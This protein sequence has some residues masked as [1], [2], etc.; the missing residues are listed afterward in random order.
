[1]NNKPMLSTF[2]SVLCCAEGGGEYWCL[3][4]CCC[5]QIT[6]CG[7]GIVDVDDDEDCDDGNT[8]DDDDCTSTYIHEAVMIAA[9][10]LTQSGTSNCW[11]LRRSGV[12]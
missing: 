1:M 9:L 3:T 7:D 11:T 10:L 4:A 2:V 12:L 5:V 8:A 6:R